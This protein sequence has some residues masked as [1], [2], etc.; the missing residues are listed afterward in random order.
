MTVNHYIF[1]SSSYSYGERI[2]LHYIL[3]GPVDKG[4]IKEVT[5]KIDGCFDG[6]RVPFGVVA[7]QTQ[8]R[9]WESICED[10]YFRDIHVLDT[11]EEFISRIKIDEFCAASVVG[12]MIVNL[13][14]CDQEKLHI[15]AF[16]SFERYYHESGRRLFKDRILVEDGLPRMDTIPRALE[17]GY[18]R[19]G[20]NGRVV[21]KCDLGAAKSRVM[22]ACDGIH[23]TFAVKE[24]VDEYGHLS[25]DELT[26]M[27]RSRMMPDGPFLDDVPGRI[28]KQTDVEGSVGN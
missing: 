13:T 4:F 17:T 15:L 21:P 25:T 10:P 26:T 7:S 24:T 18:L 14:E 1:L 11:L 19:N 8:S 6:D 27:I 16:L 20:D 5:M 28:P 9:D 3:E 23:K 2:G 22:F 12:Q